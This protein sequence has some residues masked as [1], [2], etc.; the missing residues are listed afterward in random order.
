MTGQPDI[1]GESPYDVDQILE[2]LRS[3]G[4]RITP[5]RRIIVKAVLSTRGHINPT[6]LVQQ[7]A[8]IMPDANP[9]TV[10]RTLAVLEEMGILSHVHLGSRPE[11]HLRGRAR[12]I[13]LSCIGC[14]KQ[15]AITLDEVE[16]IERAIRVASKGFTPDF[17]HFAIAGRC[18]ECATESVPDEK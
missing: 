10:Y 7:V 1:P 11:Y 14:G 12:H 6:A 4:L 17:T 2:E 15:Q 3:R 16:S 5:Q 18:A 8:D 13:H 9:S